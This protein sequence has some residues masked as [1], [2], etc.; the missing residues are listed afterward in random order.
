MMMH[1]E[2]K[3]RDKDYS[4]HFVQWQE[5]AMP[6]GTGDIELQFGGE[7]DSFYGL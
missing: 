2:T 3:M 7:N 1:Y 4:F 5:L 6:K